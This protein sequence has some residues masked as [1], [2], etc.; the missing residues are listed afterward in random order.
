MKA[1]PYRLSIRRSNIKGI[2]NGLQL[3]IDIGVIVE[4]AGD[5]LQVLTSIQAHPFQAEEL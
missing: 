1:C 5:A 4:L 3:L 2:E